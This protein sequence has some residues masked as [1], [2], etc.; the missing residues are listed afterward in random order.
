MSSIKFEFD[1]FSN[2]YFA[3]RNNKN[4]FSADSSVLVLW[5]QRDERGKFNLKPNSIHRNFK[6]L[7]DYYTDDLP[8]NVYHVS[9]WQE[10]QKFFDN[11]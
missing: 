7:S 9:D 11:E 5:Y 3:N 8:N 10:V 6:L 2:F 1:K 4:I